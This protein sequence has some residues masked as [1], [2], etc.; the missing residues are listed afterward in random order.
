MPE[1]IN[2]DHISIV[3]NKPQ[4]SENIGAA[5]RA[6]KNMGISNLV[7]VN[8]VDYN[9]DAVNKMATHAA[10]EIGRASCRERVS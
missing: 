5:A 8:P 3:L 7:I 9:P 6:A 2:F 4:F 10:M 1:K